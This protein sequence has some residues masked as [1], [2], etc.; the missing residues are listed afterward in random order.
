MDLPFEINPPGQH[1]IPAEDMILTGGVVTMSAVIPVETDGVE[2]QYP[3]VVFRFATVDGQMLPP[4]LL[5]MDEGRMIRLG[6][7]VGE[8]AKTAVIHARAA[9]RSAA[10]PV[11][12]TPAPAAGRRSP[13]ETA[14]ADADGTPRTAPP[15]D[16]TDP[17]A[18]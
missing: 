9:R 4:V 11:S 15:R 5:V 2:H 1:D 6:K 18:E 8:A 10:G 13:P 16:P 7:L 14:P 17:T 12:A 3:G